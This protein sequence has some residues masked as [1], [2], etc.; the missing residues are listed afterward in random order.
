MGP[1]QVLQPTQNPLRGFRSAEH[2]RCVNEY[3]EIEWQNRN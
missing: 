3:K 1:N 2:R